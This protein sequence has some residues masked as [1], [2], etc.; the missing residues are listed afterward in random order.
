[1]DKIIIIKIVQQLTTKLHRQQAAVDITVAQL[2]D[3]QN[4]LQKK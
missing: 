3:Y 1:M 4:Q 2:D